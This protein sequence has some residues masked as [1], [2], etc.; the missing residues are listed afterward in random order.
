MVG[1]DPRRSCG[2]LCLYRVRCGIGT[3]FA[4]VV[5]SAG[6]LVLR[7]VDPDLDRPFRAPAILVVGPLGAAS[8]LFLMFGLPVDTWIRLAVWLVIGL[9]IY[10]GYGAKHS[11]MAAIAAG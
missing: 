5:V 8:S 7:Y 2:V 4:F 1:R 6:T 3:L 11:R 9:A 10:F